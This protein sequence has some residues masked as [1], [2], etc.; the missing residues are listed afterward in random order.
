VSRII[1]LAAT[2]SACALIAAA[3]SGSNDDAA[4]PTSA[5]DE[6]PGT[7]AAEFITVESE[8]GDLVLEVPA[9]APEAEAVTV[10]VLDPADYP[11]ELAGVEQ[12]EGTVLYRL[13][14][15]G[16]EFAE[17]V[18]ITRRLDAAN[19]D[20][21][22]GELPFVLGVTYSADGTYELLEVPEISRD[23]DDVYV[24][25]E[26][27][28]FSD[29]FYMRG[30][31]ESVAPVTVVATRDTVADIGAD[32]PFPLGPGLEVEELRGLECGTDNGRLRLSRQV[33]GTDFPLWQELDDPPGSVIVGYEVVVETE[34]TEDGD[35]ADGAAPVG[36]PDSFET[37]TF[38]A[39]DH[40]ADPSFTDVAFD[41]S[42]VVAALDA[43]GIPPGGEPFMGLLSDPG[44]D[45]A[46]PDDPFASPPERMRELE[47]GLQAVMEIFNFGCY[48]SVFVPVPPEFD[49][50]SAP[51]V[52]ERL[53]DVTELG[54]PAYEPEFSGFVTAQVTEAQEI[55]VD[56]FESGDTTSW[57][58]TTP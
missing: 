6:T 20:L 22:P 49:F 48:V 37:M 42:A 44:C 34:C 16:A 13:E 7:E 29:L 45:G 31:G 50:G 51:I 1:R 25:S 17:P 10:S 3:C 39:S 18:L 58:Q 35:S 24:T 38:L 30:A 12:T 40:P 8:D 33:P 28:H 47:D 15:D 56:G 11:P 4:T 54:L 43:G 32:Y 53:T 21:G 36:F 57:S 26:A 9:G 52:W 27:T 23:G 55:Y 2:I 14:P 41:V 19:F 46:D 5:V